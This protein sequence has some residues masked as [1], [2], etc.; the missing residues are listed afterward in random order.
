EKEHVHKRREGGLAHMQYQRIAEEGW[1]DRAREV[2]ELAE[3][4]LYR[5]YE[6]V[7][8]A[9]SIESRNE[10]VE[11]LAGGQAEVMELERSARNP[12]RGDQ[13]MEDDIGAAVNSYLQEQR[14]ALISQAHERLGQGHYATGGV[15]DVV[16]VLARGQVE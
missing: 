14:D 1:R 11:N 8:V 6:L 16:G 3:K 12:D 15:A 7:V 4:Q 10:G 9:G 5:G 13:E 2:A